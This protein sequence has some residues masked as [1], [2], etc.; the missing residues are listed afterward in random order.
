[1]IQNHGVGSSQFPGG[2]L[3]VIISGTSFGVFIVIIAFVIITLIYYK[4]KYMGQDDTVHQSEEGESHAVVTV[5]LKCT[6][7]AIAILTNPCKL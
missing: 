6:Y 3:Y 4:K 1:M 5:V 2:K 7:R